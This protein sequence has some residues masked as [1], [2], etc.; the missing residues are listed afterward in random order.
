[1]VPQPQSLLFSAFGGCQRRLRSRQ[2]DGVWKQ[3][4]AAPGGLVLER[5]H[6]GR[7]DSPHRSCTQRRPSPPCPSAY[8]TAGCGRRSRTRSGGGVAAPRAGRRKKSQ[9]PLWSEPERARG[10]RTP[11]LIHGRQHSLEPRAA[12]CHHARPN[13]EAPWAPLTV[14]PMRRRARKVAAPAR[15][16]PEPREAADGDHGPEPRPC[17]HKSPRAHRG[18]AAGRWRRRRTGTSAPC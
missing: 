9:N 1:M 2:G 13:M 14:L 10:Q 16:S 12:T 6:S 4:P 3:R 5:W 7:F 17:S 8:D 11:M 15:P 18:A